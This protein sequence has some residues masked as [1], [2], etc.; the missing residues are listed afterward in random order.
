M[1]QVVAAPFRPNENVGAQKAWKE[2][3]CAMLRAS[4]I[5]GAKGRRLRTTHGNHARFR[6]NRSAP[7]W[8]APT[9]YSGRGG[10][11]KWSKQRRSCDA[12]PYHVAPLTGP[13]A[14]GRKIS[15][16]VRDNILKRTSSKSVDEGVMDTSSWDSPPCDPG[17]GSIRRW[18][19]PPPISLISPM[20][21][22]GDCLR[23]LFVVVKRQ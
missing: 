13:D 23:V 18:N 8:A 15:D 10:R 16:E 19:A 7:W 3:D 5:A 20:P 6:A 17:P 14:I 21:M 22:S 12:R 9:A 4:G 2:Q 11:G 1:A